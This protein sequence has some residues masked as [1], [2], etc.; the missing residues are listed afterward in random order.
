MTPTGDLLVESQTAPPG[1][2]DDLLDAAVSA[3]YSHTSHWIEAGGRHL[4]DVEPRYWTVRA[5]GSLVGGLAAAVRRTPGWPPR[6]RQESSLEGTSGGPV[7]HRELE[8]SLQDQV[9]SALVDSFGNNLRGGLDSCALVLD[10]VAENRFGPILAGRPGWSRQ[11]I[12]TAALSLEGGLAEV[13]LHRI[14]RNKRRERNRALR[15]GLEV[16]ITRDPDLLTAYHP[17]HVAACRVWGVAPM[18][19]EFLR[20]VLA[21]PDG[22]AFFSCA[23]LEGRVVG[24]HL[25]LHRG[26]R[27]L[28]WNGV[29][30]P[31]VSKTHYPAT[32]LVCADIEEACRRGAAWLDL[33]GS[34][35]K[36]GLAGFKEFFGAE[37]Q[38]RGLYRRD[39]AGLRLLRLG[40]GLVSS[41]RGKGRARRWH[42]AEGRDR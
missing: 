3:E 2:W 10:P 35:D 8:P 41:M 13:E 32:A 33:G 20:D 5:A 29:T 4:P 31:A 34:G 28:A 6:G 19:V 11:E 15:R 9:F 14:G 37:T 21:D 40:R 16:R 23:S 42:D 27:V 25:C 17:F 18:P 12:S 7:V 1:D 36:G 39:T 22:G 30:D 38:M 24:G 26:E